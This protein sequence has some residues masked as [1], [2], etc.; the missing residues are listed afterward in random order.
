MADPGA[1][2]FELFVHAWCTHI[3]RWPEYGSPS[4][5]A[6]REDLQHCLELCHIACHY[7]PASQSYYLERA[8]YIMWLLEKEEGQ[9]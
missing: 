1:L 7:Q 8:R 3:I 4:P 9:H 2:A 6:D 5:N